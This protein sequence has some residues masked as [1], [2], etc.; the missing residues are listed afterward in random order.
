[1]VLSIIKL[2]NLELK[3]LPTHLKYGY[4]GEN[5][6]LPL[7]IA[8]HLSSEHEKALLEVLKAHRRAIECT[9]V[10]IKGINLVLC[11]HKIQFEEGKKPVVD[12]Q[13]RL[14]SL[15]KEVVKKKELW[16]WLDVRISYTISDSEWMSP[17]QCVSK[18]DSLTMV[19]NDINELILSQIVPGWRV[20]IPTRT[21]LFA[22][23]FLLY[24]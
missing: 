9:V 17:T 19:A 6:T 16:K 5:N 23:F 7:I 22:I 15:M 21:L 24:L 3:P 18:K 8:A 13:R 4:L 14:N 2:S 1:M 11:Q 12:A 20:C 10:D